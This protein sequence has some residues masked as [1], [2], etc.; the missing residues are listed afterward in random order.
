MTHLSVGSLP[1]YPKSP[2]VFVERNEES[3]LQFAWRVIK[4]SVGTV[5]DAITSLFFRVFCFFKP[6]LGPK[7]EMIWVRI[8][9]VWL[10]IK[11]SWTKASQEKKQVELVFEKETLKQ[12][13]AQL[14]QENKR[15]RKQ[16]IEALQT[17]KENQEKWGGFEVKKE[18]MEQ[19][20]FSSQLS[21]SS[22]ETKK[23]FWEGES[24]RLQ[25]EKEIS[26]KLEQNTLGSFKTLKEVALSQFKKLSGVMQQL[27]VSQEQN[28]ALTK[29]VK[30]LRKKTHKE[31]LIAFNE[32]LVELEKAQLKKLEGI[33]KHLKTNEGGALQ[34]NVVKI[35]EGLSGKK[36]VELLAL[37]QALKDPEKSFLALD[38]LKATY[39]TEKNL[40]TA[41]FQRLFPLYAHIEGGSYV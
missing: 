18:E 23:T 35:F 2:R 22:L 26:E 30:L 14:T 15:L 12:E 13:K 4:T 1:S 17:L 34:E 8:E 40:I 27:Q 21:L 38:V 31:S 28:E 3:K 16:K 11:A 20:E 6:I 9:N 36:E 25:K 33:E 7:L 41:L 19:T 32:T 5:Y 29:E 10:K 39:Q 37:E 24:Q